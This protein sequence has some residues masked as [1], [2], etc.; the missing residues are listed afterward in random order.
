MGLTIYR[1]PFSK[2]Y[3]TDRCCLHRF[4]SKI[5]RLWPLTTY[6]WLHFSLD[7][8]LDCRFAD[9]EILSEFYG[10]WHSNWCDAIYL[11]LLWLNL[12]KKKFLRIML[13]VSFFVRWW[14]HV[15][16]LDLS[17]SLDSTYQDLLNYCFLI[18]V[19]YKL[20]KK[21]PADLKFL[22]QALFGRR[23]KVVQDTIFS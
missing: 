16:L 21:K 6:I 14:H 5:W 20:S 19:A 18:S 7:H 13:S 15:V 2:F 22:H 17:F 4:S 1:L 8:I 23:G 10:T 3:Q 9:T 11:S 12:F